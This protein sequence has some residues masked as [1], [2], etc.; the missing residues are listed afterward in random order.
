MALKFNWNYPTA[1]RFGPGRIGELVD[2]CAVAGIMKPLLVTD[3]RLSGLEMIANAL[4]MCGAAGLGVAVFD[5]VQANPV[6]RNVADG[7]P[8]YR[9]A[10]H[11]GVIAFGGGSALD[12]GKVIAFMAG[13]NPPLWGL[14]GIGGW[15]AAANIY[16]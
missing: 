2:A 9:T 4:R 10:G 14:E 8:A 1:V 7:V 16:P 11:D 13:Q 6:A 3:P 15:G 12:C 5:Q